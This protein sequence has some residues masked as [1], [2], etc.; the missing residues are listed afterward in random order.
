MSTPSR[1]LVTATRNLKN[2]PA[3]RISQRTFASSILNS[4]ASQRNATARNTTCL[5]EL[6]RAQ[7]GSGKVASSNRGQT[8]TF[9]QSTSRKALKTIDQIRARNKGG[10]CSTIPQTCI[11]EGKSNLVLDQKL[12]LYSAIQSYCSHPLRRS[13]RRIMGLF[14][15]REGAPGTKAHSGADKRNGEAQSW[16]TFSTHRSYRT[17]LQQ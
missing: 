16:W 8:R 7:N 17:A 15:I 10:V 3:A 1:C 6:Q 5:R 14:H 4:L 2:A 13:W 9:A 12:T 11:L